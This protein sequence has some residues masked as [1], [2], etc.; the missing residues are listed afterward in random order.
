MTAI[1]FIGASFEKIMRRDNSEAEDGEAFGK[2]VLAPGVKT[3]RFAFVFGD[4]GGKLLPC[5]VVLPVGFGQEKEKGSGNNG[6]ELRACFGVDR[7]TPNLAQ[8]VVGT[9]R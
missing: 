9:V 4:E 2:F 3:L 7:V 1:A 8:S 6:T 5:T